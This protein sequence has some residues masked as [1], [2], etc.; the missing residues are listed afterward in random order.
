MVNNRF[1]VSGI[2]DE[3]NTM[4]HDLQDLPWDSDFFGFPIA[5][6]DLSD[7]DR[8]ALASI[9][10]EAR[11]RGLTCIYG[12]LS[13]GSPAATYLPQESGFRLVEVAL[14]LHRRPD[15]P[16]GERLTALDI[17]RGTEDDI[18]GLDQAI[19]NLAP[20]SRFAVDPR[21]GLEAALRMHTA[22]LER[23]AQSKDD[24]RRLVVA[25]D[26]S[27]LAGCSI[28]VRSPDPHLELLG[29]TRPG[30]GSSSA[31][32]EDFLDWAG[33]V[34][35]YSG[36]TAARNVPCL[37]HLERYGFKI[38]DVEYR[39]HRWLDEEVVPV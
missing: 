30:T 26:G 28:Q 4:Q 16:R 18:P 32:M 15:Q 10:A 9:D 12:Y 1:P 36:P 35:I 6:V 25:E 17:R 24:E 37:R 19:E 11:E 34:P 38:V 14:N 7:L 31:L 23:A 3:G 5:K 27:G 20:W 39:Y 29:V 33:D 2:E 13:P 8:E 21:F 22:W